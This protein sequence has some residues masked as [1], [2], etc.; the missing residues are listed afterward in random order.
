MMHFLDYIEYVE[1]ENIKK[2]AIANYSFFEEIEQP[3]RVQFQDIINS[4]KTYYP[5]P[6]L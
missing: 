1:K 2:S 4:A 5:D 6:R 3:I